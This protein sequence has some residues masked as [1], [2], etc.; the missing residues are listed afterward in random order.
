MQPPQRSRA[1][2]SSSSS[3]SSSSSPTSP[4]TTAIV[5]SAA[6]LVLVV[7]VV[8]VDASS[9]SSPSSSTTTAE[10]TGAGATGSTGLAMTVLST[11][12]GAVLKTLKFEWPTAVKTVFWLLCLIN[13]KNVPL[14]WHFRFY[15]SLITN[16]YFSRH[17]YPSPTH[18]FTPHITASR[19]PLYESDLNGHKSN[20]TYFSDL[21]I[22][23]THL[24]AH[25]TKRSF[26]LRKQR[27]DPLMYVAL[28]GVC[29]LFRR[30]IKPFARYEL[31]SRVLGWDGKWLFVVSHF[32]TPG[33]KKD[34]GNGGHKVFAS[35][36][37]KYVFKSG[38][39]TVPPEV[40]FQESGLI[41]ERPVGS[42]VT[43]RPGSPEAG[44]EGLVEGRTAEAQV[45]RLVPGGVGEKGVEGYWSWERVEEE[46]KRGLEVARGILELDA[47]D[48][49]VRDGTEV[50]LEKLPGWF[51]GF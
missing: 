48:A 3:S 38:R 15:R 29:A 50:G 32:V 11:L 27:G 6:F 51:M 1:G 5:A 2:A 23:R 28:G 9:S 18:L 4:I 34:D 19:S 39:Q 26:Q 10:S 35:C 46:R 37:S 44:E 20:S 7:G 49:E 31:H 43:P 47:L 30:E 25:L 13:I 42:V 17:R 8:I 41:P 36:L 14:T 45:E 24:V 12:M 22:A 21:D 33:W 40:V 16:M